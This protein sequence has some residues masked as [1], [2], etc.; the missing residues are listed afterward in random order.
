MNNKVPKQK[1]IIT[2]ENLNK[3]FSQ[4]MELRNK[5]LQIATS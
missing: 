1:R 3:R 4:P 5:W 2:F